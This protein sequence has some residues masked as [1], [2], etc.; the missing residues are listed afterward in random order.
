MTEE[1]L[2]HTS[3]HGRLTTMLL[4]MIL[5]AS[6][7]V[8]RAQTISGETKEGVTTPRS[9]RTA[10]NIISTDGEE[11]APRGWCFHDI[12]SGFYYCRKTDKYFRSFC[13]C[14]KHCLS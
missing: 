10:S 1:Y 11:A 2:K 7:D 4:F 12:V 13:D 6:S 9:M 8:V 14:L 3:I 5:L